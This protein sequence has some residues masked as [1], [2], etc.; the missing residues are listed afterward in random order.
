VRTGG[1]LALRELQR[2][3]RVASRSTRLG[4]IKM[5]IYGPREGATHERICA[6]DDWELLLRATAYHEA[7]HA[8]VGHYFGKW[9]RECGL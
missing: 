7:G 4:M 1:V 9:V 2:L 5:Q 6:T 3:I 8:V